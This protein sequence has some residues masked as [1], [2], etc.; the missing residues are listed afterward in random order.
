M[1]MFSFSPNPYTRRRQLLAT[2][3]AAVSG[4]TMALLL[5]STLLS[6]LRLRS[7]A[8]ASRPHLVST[9]SFGQVALSPDGTREVRFKGGQVV[10]WDRNAG[11]PLA[12]Y[13][14][15]SIQG[16]RFTPGGTEVLVH[17]LK[18]RRV[19]GQELAHLSDHV[20][21]LDP[22]TGQK[23]GEGPYTLTR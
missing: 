1:T 16:V 3:L 8:V 15:S 18:M 6:T 19:P 14:D 12:L 11:K 17:V 22:I 4:I 23:K 2:G 20:M 5:G 21:V 13:R 9:A 10:L 7:R